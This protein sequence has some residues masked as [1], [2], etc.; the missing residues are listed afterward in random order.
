MLFPSARP[1]HLEF[2]NG[3]A[4]KGQRRRI[5]CDLWNACEVSP[6]I[7][8]HGVGL[9]AAEPARFGPQLTTKEIKVR[10]VNRK[11]SP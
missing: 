11:E 3:E 1:F 10:R 9:A 5:A 2:F 4:E 8:A 6:Q 7:T